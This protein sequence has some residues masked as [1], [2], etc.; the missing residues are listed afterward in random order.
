MAKPD[1]SLQEQLVPESFK[2]TA[3]AVAE[4]FVWQWKTAVS[5]TLKNDSGMNLYIGLAD[6]SSS[7]GSCTQANEVRGGLPPLPAPG[8]MFFSVPTSG[9]GAVLRPAFVPAGGRVS[10]TIVVSVC[11]APNPG[12][13]T[14]PLSVTLLIGKTSTVKDL[15]PYPITADAPVRQLRR[16]SGHERTPAMRDPYD[17]VGVTRGASF[18][19]I[20]AA[21]RRACKSKH[22]DMGGSHE[23]F[24]ELQAAYEW[25]L[26]DLQRG[27]QQQQHQEARSEQTQGTRHSTNAQS[28]RRREKTYRDIEEELEELRRTAEAAARVH[29]NALRAMRTS[30]WN[31][32]KH[33]E[34]AKLTWNDLA[35]FVGGIA[36]SGF[37]GL[38]LLLAALFGIGTVL[39]QANVV[40]AIV[41]VGQ[42]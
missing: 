17:I 14:A 25:I 37:K 15:V 30:A 3:S 36:R 8:Q 35:R 12:S 22:P 29:E 39:I 40:S 18:D 16:S 13:P 28:E 34:W 1:E 2:L 19:E 9:G 33:G 38:S 31:A 5:Y 32:G 41:L 20:R 21:Y 42:E 11:D 4:F 23:A 24:I 7:I 10:G 26:R 6:N 27:Y